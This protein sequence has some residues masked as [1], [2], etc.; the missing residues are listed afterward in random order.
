MHAA[1]SRYKAYMILLIDAAAALDVALNDLQHDLHTTHL[2]SLSFAHLL[3]LSALCR[4]PAQRCWH[5][6]AAGAAATDLL[7]E[8]QHQGKASKS[9]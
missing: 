9:S 6:C 1:N 5:V 4:E 7:H 8:R 2:E 3:P